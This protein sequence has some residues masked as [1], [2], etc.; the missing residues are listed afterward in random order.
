VLDGVVGCERDDGVCERWLSVYAY[1]HGV[2]GPDYGDVQVIEGVVCFSFVGEL[3]FV[4]DGVEV[5]QY[6]MYVRVFYVVYEE[7]AI[8]VSMVV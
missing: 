8:Y 7:N 4:V 2:W 3:Q 6:G 5:F 1:V